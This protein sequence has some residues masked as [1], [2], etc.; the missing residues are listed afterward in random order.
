MYLKRLATC[1]QQQNVVWGGG[2]HT[3]VSLQDGILHLSMSFQEEAEM[4]LPHASTSYKAIFFE[5]QDL[6]Y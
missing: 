4:L 1:L 3:K 2:V 5:A 6:D